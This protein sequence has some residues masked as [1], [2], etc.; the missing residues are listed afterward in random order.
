MSEIGYP[1]SDAYPCEDEELDL[2]RAAPS[3]SQ[4]LKGMPGSAVLSVYMKAKEEFQT[5]MVNAQAEMEDQ[6]RVC[7]VLSGSA[8]DSL[9]FFGNP[10]SVF[11]LRDR[12]EASRLS[13]L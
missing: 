12:P 1:P 7:P 2:F 10:F 3:K 5:E 11:A 4:H 8:A 6:I 9:I 13:G